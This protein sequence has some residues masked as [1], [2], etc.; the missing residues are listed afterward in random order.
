MGGAEGKAGHFSSHK[1]DFQKQPLGGNTTI[2]PRPQSK[3]R[4]TGSLAEAES[5]Q[6]TLDDKPSS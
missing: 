5:A 2:K 3:H 6:N 1:I 4:W